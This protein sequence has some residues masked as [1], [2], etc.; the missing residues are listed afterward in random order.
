V[1]GALWTGTA[2]RHSIH[3]GILRCIA[4]CSFTKV[5][6]VGV[7]EVTK[8]ETK[9]IHSLRGNLTDL[10]RDGGAKELNDFI[11][12][13]VSG[14]VAGKYGAGVLFIIQ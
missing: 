3:Y 7:R 9:V 6:Q 11:T 4:E 8:M 10:L 14:D 5:E 1:L 13:Y 2:F 12:G